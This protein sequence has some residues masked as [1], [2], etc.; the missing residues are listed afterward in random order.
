[1]TV[2]KC[3][4]DDCKK[5]SCTDMKSFKLHALHIHQVDFFINFANFRK[6]KELK[7]NYFYFWSV[8]LENI[9]DILNLKRAIES[10]VYSNIICVSG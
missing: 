1:M 4:I 3:P 2:Y 7:S 9:L 5:G 10:V 6:Y 8:K